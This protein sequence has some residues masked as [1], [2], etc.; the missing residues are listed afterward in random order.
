[1]ISALVLACALPAAVFAPWLPLQMAAGLAFGTAGAVFYTTLGAISLGLRPGQ[2]GA[3]SAVV[4]TVGML[5]M[6]FPAVVGAVADAQGLTAGVG[7]YL[8]IPVLVL[9]L[10]AAAVG[11]GP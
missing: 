5:G 1:V 2:A 8:A 7:L 9:A 3:T 11:G 4:S 6:G 10:A